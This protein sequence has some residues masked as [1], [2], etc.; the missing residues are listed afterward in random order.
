MAQNGGR[1]A[2]G[3]DAE[4]GRRERLHRFLCEL[5]K[6]EGRMEAAVLLGVNYRTLVKAEESGEM[7]GRMSDALERLLLTWDGGADD[8]DGDGDREPEPGGDLAQRVEALEAGLEELTR[9]LRGGLDAIRAAVGGAAKGDPAGRIGKPAAQ[10]GN[11]GKGAGSQQSPPAP[12]VA[13]LNKPRP[14]RLR[15]VDP[16]LVT[17]EPA[18]DD[19]EVYG[20]AWPL[21]KEWRELKNRLPARGRSLSWLIDYERL[22]TLELAMLE[23]H[24]LTLPPQKQPVRDS[25]GRRDHTRW[26]WKAL[27]RTQVSIRNRKL[28][29]WLRRLLTLGAWWD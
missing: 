2:G 25:L 7:T 8:G 4:A 17:R 10:A 20:D 9:E 11:G 26:R 1:G 6:R 13:G 24:G 21:V 15:R 27:D 16:E 28:L 14:V 18:G 19:A 5:V 12:P 3:Q 23:E 29:R 22:L